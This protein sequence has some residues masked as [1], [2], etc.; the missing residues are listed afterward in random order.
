MGKDTKGAFVYDAW[1]LF[2]TK[3]CTFVK[4]SVKNVL[5]NLKIIWMIKMMFQTSCVKTVK[6]VFLMNFVL[7]L[8]R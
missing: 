8:T 6:D 5:K 3:D 1:F 7:N 4:D 2:L